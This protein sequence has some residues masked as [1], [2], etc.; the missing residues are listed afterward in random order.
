ME[1]GL[2]CEI[3]VIE[4]LQSTADIWALADMIVGSADVAALNINGTSVSVFD[5]L[6]EIK[7][8]YQLGPPVEGVQAAAQLQGFEPFTFIGRLVGPNGTSEE[9][10][11]IAWTTNVLG[12]GNGFAFLVLFESAAFFPDDSSVTRRD[13]VSGSVSAAVAGNGTRMVGFPS[14]DLAIQPWC[15]SN[16]V[17][18]V[19]NLKA[20][21]IREI[22]SECGGIDDFA[23]AIEPLSSL[24]WIVVVIILVRDQGGSPSSPVFDP[25]SAPVS[26]PVID[27]ASSPVFSPST[28]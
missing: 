28:Q 27:P 8:E 9:A 6:A 15:P 10:G 3:E 20:I 12:R 22:D 25:A 24:I 1:G 7:Q 16:V 2:D 23:R 11:M 17:T 13:L 4:F 5:Y 26:A 19:L 14:Q 21:D 18:E